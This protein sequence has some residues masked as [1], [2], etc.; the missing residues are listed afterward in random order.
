MPLDSSTATAATKPIMAKRPL[1]L[2][3]AGPLKANK[4]FKFVLTCQMHT[5]MINYNSNSWA[6]NNTIGL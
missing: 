3:G 4:S 6:Q 2:S 5:N 1:I